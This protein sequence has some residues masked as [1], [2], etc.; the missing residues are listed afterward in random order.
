MPV[1]IVGMHRSGTSMVALLLAECG[2]Y[3]GPERDLMP[4]GPDNP[5]GFGENLR[6]VELNERLLATL[7]GSW[8]ALPEFGPGWLERPDVAALR[9]EAEHVVHAF[10]E[11]GPWG[12]KDP[13]SSVTFPFWER[14]ADRLDT[15]VCIRDPLE[16]ALS[17]QRR[18]GLSLDFGLAL[19]LQYNER[20]VATTHVESRIVSHYDAYFSSPRRELERVAA[21]ID[22]PVDPESVERAAEGALSSVRSYRLTRPYLHRAD[23]LAPVAELYRTLCGEADWDA[24]APAKVKSRPP[25]TRVEKGGKA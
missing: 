4:P 16:V 7:G 18:D 22:L 13:R 17:L 25:Q 1:S 11:C 6:F 24:K 19:W 14:V 12:W 8:D 2:L 3:L 21:F 10:A 9:A 15:V 20:I 23:V 5:A